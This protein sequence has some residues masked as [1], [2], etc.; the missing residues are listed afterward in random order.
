MEE[1][2]LNVGSVGPVQEVAKPEVITITGPDGR[3]APVLL[4]PN[5]KG[6]MEVHDGLLFIEDYQPRE[7]PHR[8]KGTAVLE[9]LQSFVDHVLRFA[10][11]E[12]RIFIQRGGPQVLAVY[13]YHSPE[14]PA[15]GE[16]RAKFTFAATTTW[17]AWRNIHGRELDQTAFAEFL[18]NRSADLISP[19]GLPASAREAI[20]EAEKATGA[21]CVHPD[22]IR[23]LA[24]GLEYHRQASSVEFR[25]LR[26]GEVK[27]SF[28]EKLSGKDGE[29]LD[30]PGLF[31]IAVELF[32]ARMPGDVDPN[33]ASKR[34]PPKASRYVIPVRLRV[35]PG[36]SDNDGLKWTMLLHNV[37][38]CVDMALTEAADRVANETKV[39][40]LWGM[41]ET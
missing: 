7:R 28:E 11:A 30:I 1:Q 16:H 18:E 34:L 40:V 29:V 22:A 20:L 31:A 6:S 37:D 12:T 35:R 17:A 25:N 26:T 32:D 4:V 5:G 38:R 8:R 10:R 13:D 27:V 36:K 23:L 33:D 24:R 3:S 9:S 41:P 15:F 39:P 21:T 14:D 19:D 2:M